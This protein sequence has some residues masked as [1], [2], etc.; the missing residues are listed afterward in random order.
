MASGSVDL[1]AVMA[2]HRPA[3]LRLC[4]RR[5]GGDRHLAEDV[6]QETFLKLGRAIDR[7]QE[8]EHLGAWLRTVAQNGTVDELRRSSPMLLVEP[9]D[10][11]V[12]ATSSADGNP[13]LEVA[14]QGLNP[15]HQEV[16]RLRELEGLRYEEIATVMAT[17][18]SAVETLLFRARAALRREYSRAAAMTT[19]PAPVAVGPLRSWQPSGWFGR[20]A[21][22]TAT[23]QLRLGV[24]ADRVV[25]VAGGLAIAGAAAAASLLG[26]SAAVE[27]A[28]PVDVPAVTS[29]VVPPVAVPPAPT[30]PAA[31]TVPPTTPA[32]PEVAPPA[33]PTPI[34]DTVTVVADLL[35]D[36]SGL[37]EEILGATASNR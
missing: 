20:A 11:V 5:L 30:V 9:P 18:V 28:P 7:G 2:E 32:S 13:E 27:A 33:P 3:L 35:D 17:R 16:L 14:W 23:L 29:S 31:P 19:V 26:P 12:D 15:R 10:A 8:I 21:D 24:L 6:V 1:A 4:T 25:E 34:R 37:V 22:A 36:A